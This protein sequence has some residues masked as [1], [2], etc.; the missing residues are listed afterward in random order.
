MKYR[1]IA[2]SLVLPVVAVCGW[3]AIAWHSV[4][5]QNDAAAFLTVVANQIVRPELRLAVEQIQ[6]REPD[7]SSK[8]LDAIFQCTIPTICHKD[9]K[10]YIR[11]GLIEGKYL[12][13]EPL[14]YQFLRTC[15]DMLLPQI[16]A[17]QEQKIDRGG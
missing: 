2:L 10:R 14:S 16:A 4:G 1:L 12:T 15:P 17:E 11:S 9:L 6:C 3:F 5:S 8:S 13:A 7:F